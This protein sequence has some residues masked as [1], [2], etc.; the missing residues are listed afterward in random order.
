MQL[1]CHLV[2]E[3]GRFGSRQFVVAARSVAGGAWLTPSWEHGAGGASDR[4]LKLGKGG[5]WRC[6]SLGSVYVSPA[7]PDTLRLSHLLREPQQT[8]RP[9]TMVRAGARIVHAKLQ[10]RLVAHRRTAEMPRAES[11]HGGF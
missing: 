11:V 7:A 10:Q 9:T 6:L 4:T 2:G 3:I 1:I 8:C 5:N